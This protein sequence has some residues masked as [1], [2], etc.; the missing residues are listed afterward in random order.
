M[1]A[2]LHLWRA[3]SPVQRIEASAWAAASALA[4]L[5]AHAAWHAANARSFLWNASAHDY[6]KLEAV[7]EVLEG[8]M[9]PSTARAICQLALSAAWY[10]SNTRRL[11]LLDAARDWRRFSDIVAGLDTHLPAEMTRALKTLTISAAW[12]AANARSMMWRDAERDVQH[13]EACCRRLPG[14]LQR[15]A[16]CSLPDERNSPRPGLPAATGM[17]AAARAP[18]AARRQRS[19]A[20]H[21]PRT[22]ST[23][24]RSGRAALQ[25]THCVLDDVIPLWQTAANACAGACVGASAGA[26][27]GVRAGEATRSTSE[28]GRGAGGG[29]GE[30]NGGGGV[31]D[32]GSVLCSDFLEAAFATAAVFEC[33]GATVAPMASELQKNADKLRKAMMLRPGL[34]IREMVVEESSLR[35]IGRRRAA[36]VAV[37]GS[38]SLALIWLGR[39]LRMLLDMMKRLAADENAKLSDCIAR[40][41]SDTLQAYHALWTQR[42]I[43]A[44]VWTAPSRGDFLTRLGS[45]RVTVEQSI[46]ELL[47]CLGPALACV[48]GDVMDVLGEAG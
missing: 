32:G 4:S 25:R 41:Y 44:A 39:L 22:A 24:T 34:T 10:A 3:P 38:A 7:A 19:A 29:S 6:E 15:S 42:V 17:P 28:S 23:L 45:D 33:L 30:L 21:V 14:L 48:Q 12:H 43:L 13:F 20:E 11:L 27:A 9:P 18:R 37:E 40:A 31:S 1:Q 35:S 16:I 47:A 36:D 8:L 26:G 46:G 5:S 2:L